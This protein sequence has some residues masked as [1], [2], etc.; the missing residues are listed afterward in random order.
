MPICNDDGVALVI[1]M[2]AMLLLAALGAALVLT[3]SSETVIA[4]NYRNSGEAL[5]AADAIVE[6]AL[7]GLLTVSD[8]NALLNSSQG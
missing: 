3:T 4:G 6:R 8:W 5:Y 7:D 2:M 1:A